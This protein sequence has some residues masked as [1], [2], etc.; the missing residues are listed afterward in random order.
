MKK[1]ILLALFL[2]VITIIFS[3]NIINYDLISYL[4]VG[5][6]ISKK[7]NI[8]PE[9]AKNH[10]PYFPLYLYLQMIPFIIKKFIVFIDP[11]LFFKIVNIF[12]DLL[13]L[14]L[15]YLISNK[16]V[17]NALI[18]GLNPITILISCFHGQF[19]VIVIF[20]LL[21]SLYL[22]IK[23]NDEILALLSFSLA[24]TLKHWPIIFIFPVIKK[25]KNK[26]YL[27]LIPILPI[28][29]TI[30]YLLIF[31]SKIFDI[32]YP[33]ISYR[34]LFSGWGFGKLI[35]LLF[36]SRFDQPP[37]YLQK[38]FLIF[39]SCFL[40]LYSWF[41]REKNLI[42]YFLKILVFFYCFTF[43]FSIQYLSWFVPFLIIL[44]PK[45]FKIII[46]NTTIYL[47]INYFS[48][49][50]KNISISNN[51]QIFFSLFLWLNFFLLLIYLHKKRLKTI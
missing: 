45:F 2:R 44:K 28:M 50:N 51:V 10:Y 3:H 40:L 32:L 11:I 5:E 1:I 6:L 15:V 17:N 42:M 33:I 43:G 49:Y 19:D 39:F 12:F 21:L 18:Y 23:K 24:I 16:N 46:A 13:N 34:S 35:Y 29:F 7:I 26:K 41:L 14:Y 38:I 25:I 37:I 48:W 9:V 22:F 31:K 30:I 8:Y 47:F 27:S 36:Y 20:F 4:K